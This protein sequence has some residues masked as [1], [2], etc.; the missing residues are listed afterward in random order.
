M[1]ST[2]APRNIHN[3]PAG[4]PFA[5]AL[6]SGIVDLAGTAEDLARATILV[7]SRRAALSLRAAFLEIRG[8]EAT[9]LPRIEPIGDVEEDSPEILGFAAD[10]AALPPA[11]D[12]LC[13]Q[14]WLARLLEGFAMGGV[15][16]TPP[17]AMQLADSLARLLDALCNV[18]STPDQ[19]VSLLPERFSRHWQ[20][21]LKLLTILIDRWPA[22]LAEQGVLDP[23]DRRNRLIRLR[24]EAWRQVP[25]CDLVLVAGSTGTFAATRELIACVASLPNGHVVLPGLDH[26][27]ADHWQ[28]IH[29]DAGH[30]QHQLSVL[31]E[32]LGVGPSDVTLWQVA[33]GFAEEGGLRRELMRE[34]FKPAALSADWRRLGTTNP[35]LGRDA[36]IGLSIVECGTR[37]EEAGL[38]A[39]AMRE[40][41]ETPGRTAALVTPDRQLAEAV[42]AGL[43]RWR[44][45]VDDSAGRP[46]SGC[47]VGGFLHSM[48]IMVA[49]AFAPVP[50]LAFLKHPLVAGGLAPA[51]FRSHLRAM[52]LAALRG[53]RPAEGLAGIRDRLAGD[54]DLLAFFEAH[55]AAPLAPLTDAWSAPASDIASLARALGS[56]AH[57]TSLR[58]LSVG[59][60][61]AN[62]AISLDFLEKLTHSSAAFEHLH[63]VLSALDDI[64][65]LPISRTEATKLRHG[66]K[67]PALG[68]SAQQRFAMLMTGITAIALEGQTPVA[69]VVLKAGAICPVRVLNL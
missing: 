36:L 8:D 38:I 30:P 26:G 27:A 41:L 56:A 48:V 1:T 59:Q 69:L 46:L 55:I 18:D 22:I 47:P 15:A 13:R 20:D 67:L 39:I 12:T 43:Q 10:G 11:M 9:L 63:P 25:P 19:L 4:V 32:V 62:H 35:H 54:D 5:T 42:I 52:E 21:I 31:L 49:E 53:Y 6:A 34:A 66:Q 14:L 57:V 61:H 50:T 29:Q 64:P 33:D 44:I 7:P 37:A 23:A 28:E 58:R 45:D 3:I 16:P 65:A 40:V 24:C 60:F 17:Q 51:R 2:P 68:A